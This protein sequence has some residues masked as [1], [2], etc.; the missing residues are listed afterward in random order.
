LGKQPSPTSPARLAVVDRQ[1]RAL[2]YR[3]AGK[4]YPWI[5]DAMGYSLNGVFKAVKT[6]LKRCGKPAADEVR[7]MEL[8]RL[9]RLW[10]NLWG[11]D[12]SLIE[13]KSAD[14]LVKKTD[15]M[16]R[17]SKRRAD[18]LGID[19]PVKVAATTPGGESIFVNYTDEQL[20]AALERVRAR[21][22]LGGALPVD[23][24]CTAQPTASS[25]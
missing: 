18:M 10:Q 25:R 13:C 9:D 5:A 19:A 1:N 11:Q 24:Q 6:A 8:E 12:G 22:D 16:I 2:E 21:R 7:I 4:S 17:I 3:K 14:D 23:S 15:A 20:L